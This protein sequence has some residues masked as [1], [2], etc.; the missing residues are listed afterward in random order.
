MKRR[1]TYSYSRQRAFTLAEIMVVVVIISVITAVSLPSLR[2]MAKNNRLRTS[3]R[4]LMSLMKYA[5]SEAVFNG[6]TT[7]VFLDTANREFWLDLRTPD[8]KTGKYDPRAP[9]ASMERKRTL[10]NEVFFA[11]VNALNDN[12][13]DGKIIAIDFFPDGTASPVMISLANAQDVSYTIEVLKSTGLVEMNKGD[14]ETVAEEKGQL[15]YP[16]P[17]NYNEAYGSSAEGSY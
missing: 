3:V 1:L 16:L 8:P 17:P 4:E 9:K 12:I 15:S 6:R 14:L 2:G 10:E 11:S 13:I 7:E 5:R